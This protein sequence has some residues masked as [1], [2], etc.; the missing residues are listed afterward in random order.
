MNV[1]SFAVRERILARTF[2]VQTYRSNKREFGGEGT[3]KDKSGG[4]G[5]SF[6]YTEKRDTK[7]AVIGRL[8]EGREGY[9]GEQEGEG[10]GGC[11]RS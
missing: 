10:G 1:V 7:E 8:S 9:N 4:V 5:S 3:T 6:D 2:V 11:V